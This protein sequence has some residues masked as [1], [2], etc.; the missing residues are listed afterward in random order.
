MPLE[1]LLR[2]ADIAMYQAKKEGGDRV[3]SYD[4]EIDLRLRQRVQ[5]AS[6]LREAL[7]NGQISVVYQVIVDAQAQAI[8][9]VEALAR[10]VLADGTVVGPEMF[11][12]LA[13]ENGLIEELGTHVLR[14]ACIGAAQWPDIL[15]SVNVSPVQFHNPRFDALIGDILAETGFPPERLDLEFTE[16][17]L[18]SD[19]DQAFA[20]MQ[21]LKERG[22]SISLDDFGTGYSSIGYLKRFKFDR[23]KLDQSI[24][25]DV[26]RDADAQQMIQGTITIA[27]SLGLEVTAEGVENEQ[28]AVLLRLAGCRRLQGYF[29]GE[30]MTAEDLQQVLV[31]KTPSLAATA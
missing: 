3:G 31:P 17:H 23:L 10:W 25:A 5:L 8:C 28:Q 12:P 15:L 26:T 29:F 24:C 11:I 7:K 13:E 20:A 6:A 22:I 30:P 21:K 16:R 19:P 4:A 1:E 18:V 27:R 14:Q 2:R 9:G